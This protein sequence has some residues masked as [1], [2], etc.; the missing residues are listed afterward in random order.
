MHGCRRAAV[1]LTL[2]SSLWGTAD[3]QQTV[4][5]AE[6]Q[7]AALTAE[8]LEEHA[9]AAAFRTAVLPERRVL[10]GGATVDVTLPLPHRDRHAFCG[11]LR[12]DPRPVRVLSVRPGSDGQAATTVL[13][14]SL[15]NPGNWLYPSRELILVSFPLDSSS[16]LLKLDLPAVSVVER[17]KVSHAWL[18][19]LG[20]LAIVAMAYGLAVAAVGRRGKAHSWDPVWLTAGPKGQASL[21]QF[22]IFGFTLLVVGLLSYVLLRTWVL[23]DISS[24]VL[25]LLGISA[26][27]AAGSNTASVLKKRLRFENWSWLRNRG[28][29]I[30]HERGVEGGAPHPPIRWG[31]LLKTDGQFDI[32]SFQLATVSLVVAVALVTSDLGKL[33]SFVLPGNILALLGLSNAVFI[34]GKVV[35]PPSFGELDQKVDAVR[36]GEQAWR[37][38]KAELEAEEGARKPNA[39]KVTKAKA[40]TA[41]LLQAFKVA[42]R[43]AARMLKALFGAEGTKFKTEPIRDEDILP[44]P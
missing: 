33:A 7:C 26:G 25:L 2:W 31:D 1:S 22:Q 16:G 44:P 28:W 34:G 4:P 41:E 40:T 24:D 11:R 29:L 18:A 42:A 23:T 43:E 19:R 5:S 39:E 35:A 14:L 9:R 8:R 12:P 32:Y 37:A 10:P 15:P 20:A 36:Q 13:S 17:V 30:A 21:S 38:A 3:A 6:Q 27:G